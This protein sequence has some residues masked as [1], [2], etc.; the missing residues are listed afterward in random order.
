MQITV[1]IENTS[2]SE[3]KCEHG[4][5]LFIE[6]NDKKYLLDAGSTAAFLENARALQIPVLQ[7]DRCILSHGHY[8]HSGGFAEY[9]A[10]NP[11]A[12]VYAMQGADGEYYSGSGG[13]I[14][15]IGIP[16]N[17]LMKYRDRFCWID[18]VFQL[19]PEVYL[20][21]HSV[22][23]LEKIGARAKLYRKSGGEYLPDD[24]SHELSLV[25]DTEKGLVIFNSCSH[26]GIMNII[27]EVKHV[28][29]GK[30]VYAF[31][32][33]LHMKGKKNGKEICTFS[34]DE[35]LKMAD[36][37]KKTGV[38]YLYTGHCTGQQGFALLKKYLGTI[39]Q[40]LITGCRIEL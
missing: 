14:H 16:E 38:Q 26:A 28:L 8:D 19:D 32:G 30:E 40:P 22:S 25:F 21:P 7:A 27:E 18:K 23:G 6:Y 35:V 24:F 20:I 1:L 17:V 3:L 5:S 13:E 11:G 36:S 10:Q 9:L 4:L 31:L 12:E 37:L 29:P 2:D 15:P 34:D 33:G 39:V